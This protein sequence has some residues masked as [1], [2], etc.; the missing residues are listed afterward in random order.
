M[1]ELPIVVNMTVDASR[2]EYD[3]T[4]ESN[5]EEIELLNDTVIETGGSH[6]PVYEGPY[7][8]DAGLTAVTLD[9]DGKRMTQDV[10]VNALTEN[11]LSDINLSVNTSN[12]EVTADVSLSAGYNPLG[13]GKIETL[14]L[15]TQS[16]RTITPTASEQTAVARNKY[17]LGAVKVGPIPSPYADVSGVTAQASDVLAGKYFVNNLGVLTLGTG[18]GGMDAETKDA[19]LECF[20]HVAWADSDGQ[21]YYN[22]LLNALYPLQSISAVYTQS[23]TVTPSTPLDNLKSDLV[24]TAT[25]EDGTTKTVTNYTL[26]GTLTAGTSTIT[27]TYFTET[28]TFNVTVSSGYV[29][30]DYLQGDG[31]AFID[32]GLLS[33]TYAGDSYIKY[34]E[35]EIVDSTVD[36][37]M[38]G[39]RNKWGYTGLLAC[40]GS[41]GFAIAFGNKWTSIAG[42]TTGDLIKLTLNH[43]NV[44][45]DGVT[46]GTVSSATPTIGSNT[47]TIP[48]FAGSNYQ[49]RPSETYVSL[50]G[51]YYFQFSHHKL[52]RFTVT[53]KSTGT[54]IAD[55]KPATY[56]GVPGLYDTVRD[57]FFTNAN[58]SGS[59]TIGNDG[60]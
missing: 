46:V 55:M 18:G 58:S 41:T 40:T 33:K 56:Q 43:P 23:G 19:L 4:A 44:I 9:T 35:F 22:N 17:T 10:T 39:C 21:I 54:V 15:P 29:Y 8:V 28:T 38:F 24:V 2:T 50:N 51:G 37:T 13:K 27:V 6:V 45:N 1:T 57:M 16:A 30:Y 31:T 53:E 11:T 52:Y 47:L 20:E 26:S 14:V 42:K 3:L 5:L 12:G 7:T 59:F 36:K 49:E 60:A 25:F 48:L 34:A 32:T